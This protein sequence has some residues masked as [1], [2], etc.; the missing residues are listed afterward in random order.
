MISTR[1]KGIFQSD[2]LIRT[3]V[4][5]ALEDMRDNPWLLDFAFSWLANDDLTK[6]DKHYGVDGIEEAKTWFKNTKI[7][8]VMSFR[9]DRPQ[10]PCI[11]IELVD[12]S[13]NGA[14]SLGD[15]SSEGATESIEASDI[16]I[17]PRPI[18]GPF[19]PK[20]YDSSTGTVTLPSGTTTSGVFAGNVLYDSKTNRGFIVKDV[21]DDSRFRIDAGVRAN[22]THAYV[23]AS[24]QMHVAHL[25]SVEFQ[26]TY[27]LRCYV[28]TAPVHL[29]YL[30]SILTFALLR[31]KQDLLEARGF[32]R[33]TIRSQNIFE[34]QGADAAELLFARDT[35]ISGYVRQYWPK[36]ILPQIH[37]IAVGPLKVIGGGV[38]PTGIQS[39]VEEQ[40]WMMDEDQLAGLRR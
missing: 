15:V 5:A 18:L 39:A 38:S 28:N 36:S 26:E 40:G 32:E 14:N 2:V 19:T 17:R 37:G 29:L 8:V 4:L 30:Y 1:T 31:Y 24:S 9:T 10:L 20:S 22:F 34:P 12:S 6:G 27:R 25:E 11:A 7:A 16:V 13:E 23:A 3:A 33:T 35:V 21:V